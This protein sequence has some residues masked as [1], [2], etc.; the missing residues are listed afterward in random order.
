MEDDFTKRFLAARS[1]ETRRSVVGAE[2]KRHA[3]ATGYQSRPTWGHETGVYIAVQW[4]DH[5]ADNLNTLMSLQGALNAY[6]EIDWPLYFRVPGD[7][8][9]EP[10]FVLSRDTPSD[11]LRKAQYVTEAVRAWLASQS[12]QS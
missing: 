5:L 10:A 12:A 11:L 1:D 8:P 3:E 9:D 7:N 6:G 2:I 4:S